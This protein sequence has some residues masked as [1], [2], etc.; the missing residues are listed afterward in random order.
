MISHPA[1]HQGGLLA[2]PGMRRDLLYRGCVSFSVLT[3]G[4]WESK[5]G[6]GPA[7]L[8]FDTVPRSDILGFVTPESVLVVV[9]GSLIVVVAFP[10]FRGD[11]RATR[12]SG[13]L[14][15]RRSYSI[16]RR[17]WRVLRSGWSSSIVLSS[18]AEYG[19]APPPEK[20]RYRVA[21]RP[22]LLHSHRQ[23]AC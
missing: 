15:R 2:A 8:G 6:P 14:L 17:S 7:L 3:T 1:G 21:E 22:S 20:D 13:H 10:L 11:Q 18:T 19:A 12:P 9:P 4:L 16:H 5:E 23:L